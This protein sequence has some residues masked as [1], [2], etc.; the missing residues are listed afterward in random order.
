LTYSGGG[1]GGGKNVHMGGEGGRGGKNGYET[2]HAEEGEEVGVTYGRGYT[3]SQ[4]S[5]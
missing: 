2:P 3:F 1:G 4:V 5:S